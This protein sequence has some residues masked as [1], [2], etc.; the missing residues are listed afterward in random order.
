MKTI[1]PTPFTGA[2]NLGAKERGT[3][4]LYMAVEIPL[5]SNALSVVLGGGAGTGSQA[6][7]GLLAGSCHLLG[8]IKPFNY[9]LWDSCV[10][11]PCGLTGHGMGWAGRGKRVS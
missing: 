5:S 7:V 1:S 10:I 9:T 4:S 6:E 11:C 2:Q 3:L 8:E